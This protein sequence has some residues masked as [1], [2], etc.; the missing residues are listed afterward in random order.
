MSTRNELLDQVTKVLGHFK[1]IVE[2]LHTQIHGQWRLGIE[3]DNDDV[4]MRLQRLA[5]N[6]SVYY[7]TVKQG[8]TSTNIGDIPNFFIRDDQGNFLGI[9]YAAPNIDNS[10]VGKRVM[11]L[12]HGMSEE[13]CHKTYIARQAY[14]YT[15][16]TK[17]FIEQRYP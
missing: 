9:V 17:S 1:I 3:F 15:R 4:E 7:N 10:T 16:T 8:T 6:F 14:D 13:D 11:V 12:C 5:D 2:I